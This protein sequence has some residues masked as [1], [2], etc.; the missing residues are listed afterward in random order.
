[1]KKGLAPPPKKQYIPP[2]KLKPTPLRVDPLDGDGL[3]GILPVDLILVLRKLAK[4]DVVTRGRALEELE[5][6]IRDVKAQNDA[7]MLEALVTMLPVWVSYSVMLRSLLNI[8]LV[9]SLPRIMRPPIPPPPST[10]C[11]NSC[12]PPVHSRNSTCCH[13]LHKRNGL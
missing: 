2:S 7:V 8:E 3:A 12:T 1:M 6:W 13:S 5:A 4:K 9:P 10:L 11:F